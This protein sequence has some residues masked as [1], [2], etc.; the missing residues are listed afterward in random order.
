MSSV[1]TNEEIEAMS[2][3]IDKQLGEI[4]TAFESDNVKGVT[5][6]A[7]KPPEKQ[8]KAIQDASKEET[9]T[10]LQKFGKAAKQNLCKKGG[11]LYD[12]HKKW[13]DLN[14]KD[15]LIQ[16]GAILTT[17]GFAGNK[18]QVLAVALGV[19]VIHIGVDAFCMED[20]K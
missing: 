15:V 2:A 8:A 6:R 18:L 5:K 16:F 13:G 17:M 9:L 1:F 3:E 12:Y 20:E 19:I 10:F 7:K 4:P 14:N 11:V